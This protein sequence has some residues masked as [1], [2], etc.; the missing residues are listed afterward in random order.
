MAKWEPEKYRYMCLQ[1]NS[2]AKEIKL[3]ANYNSEHAGGL[4]KNDGICLITG[5][6]LMMM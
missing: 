6:L 3:N 5:L 4:K 2:N 1:C